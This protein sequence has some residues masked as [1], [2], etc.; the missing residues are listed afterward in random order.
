MYEQQQQ[1]KDIVRWYVAS[2]K[3]L[4]VKYIKGELTTIDRNTGWYEVP[5]LDTFEQHSS[6]LMYVVQDKKEGG[7]I[8]TDHSFSTSVVVT[9]KHNSSKIEIHNYG[10]LICVKLIGEEAEMLF[11]QDGSLVHSGT[12][13]FNSPLTAKYRYYYDYED[14]N[15]DLFS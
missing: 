13:L 11:D 3:E 12:N 1:L 4:T 8:T 15:L 9:M 2:V 6:S 14:D 10:L 5:K 7:M